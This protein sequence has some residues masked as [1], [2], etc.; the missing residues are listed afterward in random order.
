MKAIISIFI[1]HYP[2]DLACRMQVMIFDMKCPACK[3]P[4]IKVKPVCSCRQC[5]F[6]NRAELAGEI[7]ESGQKDQGCR[8]Y[9]LKMPEKRY[10]FC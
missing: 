6:R 4:V 8:V 9:E 7:K 1:D 2:G 5:R 3:E 10:K